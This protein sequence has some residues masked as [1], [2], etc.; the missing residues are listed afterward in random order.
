MRNFNYLQNL[1]FSQYRP[2]KSLLHQLHPRLK[3][4]SLIM[5]GTVVFFLSSPLPLGLFFF[6][7]VLGAF[8]A[9]LKSLSLFRGS[10]PVLPFLALIALVQIFFI[11]GDQGAEVLFSLWGRDVYREGLVFTALLFGRF[12][13][14]FYLFSLFSSITSISELS[15][16]TQGLLRPLTG[17]SGLS[18]DGALLVVL[19]FRFIPL[20][21]MEAE[22][23]TKAQAA[24][25]AGFGTWRGGPVKR[26]RLALP[27]LVPLFTGALEHA[28]ILAEAMEARCYEPG[29][30]RTSLD[31][32]FWR[33]QDSLFLFFL[34]CFFMLLWGLQ[35]RGFRLW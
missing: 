22:Y 17:K 8:S 30:N 33:I 3:I 18:H 35:K 14:L 4:L 28:G 13:C 31:E 27:L 21:L 12:F 6:L 7:L 2:G 32:Y 10:A 24:R 9:G 19:V 15:H 5:A 20:M 1:A 11:H 16:G 26:I 34:L 23:L 29:R 25:G